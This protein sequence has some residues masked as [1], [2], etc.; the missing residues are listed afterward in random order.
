MEAIVRRCELPRAQT[1]FGDE[2]DTLAYTRREKWV[3]TKRETRILHLYLTA[4]E[5]KIQVGRRGEEVDVL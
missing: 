1:Y 5:G 2:L 3:K 4:K